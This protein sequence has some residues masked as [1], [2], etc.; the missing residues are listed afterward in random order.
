MSTRST[1]SAPAAPSSRHRT[2]MAHEGS[3][4]TLIRTDARVRTPASSQAGRI[5]AVIVPASR[6]AAALDG[7]ANLASRLGATLVALCS[8]QT[9]GD[10]VAE[11]A[12][13][14]PGCRVLSIDVPAGYRHDLMP[15][16]TVAGRFRKAGADRTTDLSLKRNLGLLL[17]R[18]HNWGKILFLDDDIGC[19]FGGKPAGLHDNAVRRLVAALDAHQIAGLTC[20]EFPDNSVVCH[21]RR[22]AGFAQDT[23]IS[24]AALGVNCNDHPL[25]FFPD[26]YNEDWFFFSRRVAARDLAHVGDATQAAY[27][28]FESPERARQEE[29]GDLLAEGLFTLFASQPEEMEYRRRLAAAD[30]WYWERFI[31]ARR[32]AVN[33]T[34]IALEIAL[35]SGTGD[36][37]RLAAALRS[38]DAATGQLSRLTPELCVDYLAAWVDDLVEWEQ[39]TLRVRAVGG[40]AEAADF[41]GLRQW[42]VAG[43]RAAAR[44]SVWTSD[45]P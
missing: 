10:A 32:A 17:A 15:T 6:S 3:H 28:P 13:R 5:D 11:R 41:L 35:E 29:F 34:G 1:L 38:L 23:F 2:L 18:L 4:E 19:T 26:Q 30:V 14:M 37:R 12:A 20:R 36:A 31:A 39:A 7:A 33:L 40:T 45:V 42:C 44:G 9:N 25:P 16:R 24:G 43:G 8:Q 27:D 22:L 21:A